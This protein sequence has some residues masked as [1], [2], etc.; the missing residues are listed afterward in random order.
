VEQVTGIAA[1]AD[2]DLELLWEPDAQLAD[3]CVWDDR[4]REVIFA[5][6]RSGRVYAYATDDGS[7]RHWQLPETVGS[8]GVCESGRLLVAL[9]RRVVLLDRGTGEISEFGERIGEPEG[10][11][12]NDGKVGPDGCFW[13]GTR[14]ARRDH[15]DVPAGNGR[16]YR[17]T[18]DGAMEPKADGIVTSNGLAWSGDG[19]TMFHSDSHLMHI[20]AYD[21]DPATGSLSG[22][23]R[24]AQLGEA[25]G[26]PDGAACD[27]DGHYWSAA[28]SV[29]CLNKF[30]PSG[31]LIEQLR[32][33]VEAP[34]MPCFASDWLYVTSRFRA[35]GP[36]VQGRRHNVAGLFRM[37]A[38]AQGV[39]VGRFDD[40]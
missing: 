13:V 34:T 17:L 12:L 10:N 25:E 23:R 40:T 4:T 19:K 28:V 5:D 15:G 31:A 8:V 36:D 18:P 39:R 24:I 37:P 32:V 35:P 11:R 26:R 21:F 6:L 38:P 3:G 14:D 30:S 9:R 27:T 29:G 16:L 33:P 7:R 2:A 1:A 22:M 20:D